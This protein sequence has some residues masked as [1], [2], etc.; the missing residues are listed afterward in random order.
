[1]I[2]KKM[3]EALNGQLNAEAYSAYLYL[4]MSAYLESV[5][6]RGFGNWMRMQARE[7]MTHAMKFYR[8]IL[9]RGGKVHLS[10]IAAPKASW[11]SPQEVF[12]D[13]CRH[14][15]KV[16]GLINDLVKLAGAEKDQAAGD[17]L[18]WFVKEQVEEESAADEVLQKVKLRGGKGDGLLPLDEELGRRT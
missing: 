3:E 7:E 12:E 17:F 8:H 4:S 13:T 14:E 16:T 2:S 5:G 15:R 6:L 9:D 18:Q 10:S 11:D 1:M